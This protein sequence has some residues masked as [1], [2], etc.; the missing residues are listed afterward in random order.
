VATTASGVNVTPSATL[1]GLLSDFEYVK[2]VVDIMDYYAGSAT[3]GEVKT[4]TPHAAH[5]MEKKFEIASVSLEGFVKNQSKYRACEGFTTQQPA[6]SKIPRAWTTRR[7]RHFR[8]FNVSN[9]SQ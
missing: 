9:M 1:N 5:Y 6:L 3:G 7:Y 4:A 2:G 8:H